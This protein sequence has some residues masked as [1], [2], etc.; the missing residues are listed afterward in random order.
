MFEINCFEYT[1]TDVLDD[2]V[3]D[4]FSKTTIAQVD[5]CVDKLLSGGVQRKPDIAKGMGDD[6][7]EQ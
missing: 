3:F 1:A 4:F 6:L 2:M 7:L 5:P